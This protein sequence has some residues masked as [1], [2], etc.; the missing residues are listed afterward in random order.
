MQHMICHPWRCFRSEGH[1][2][3]WQV[4]NMTARVQRGLHFS[5]ASQL[6]TLH[7]ASS[8][9]GASRYTAAQE[10]HRHKHELIQQALA[11]KPSSIKHSLSVDG[12]GRRSFTESTAHAVTASPCGYKHKMEERHSDNLPNNC[13][14][15]RTNQRCTPRT[16]AWRGWDALHLTA[17]DEWQPRTQAHGLLRRLICPRRL[18]HPHQRCHLLLPWQ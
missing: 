2:R 3:I 4:S 18:H 10:F 8:G 5:T 13:T 11:P 7:P 9:V 1:R 15:M 17:A 14:R 16:R 12:H 6:H